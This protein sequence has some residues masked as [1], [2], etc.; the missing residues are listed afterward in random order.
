MGGEIDRAA[1][2]DQD[3]VLQ[4]HPDP[5]L[6]D[7]DAGLDGD[8]PARL[9]G[10]VERREVVD[11]KPER[12]PEAVHEIL[13]AGRFLR[14]VLGDLLRRDQAEAEKLVVHLE[15]GS[16]APVA[17]RRA[18]GG[19][20]DRG[21]EDAVDRVVHRALPRGEAA[22]DGIGAGQV[23]VVVGVAGADVDKEQLAVVADPVVGVVVEDAGALPRGDDRL[24]GHLRPV[25]RE[26]VDQLRLEF[27][28]HHPRLEAGE[29][30][31]QADVG[32]VD[33]PAEELHF[34]RILHG[35]QVSHDRRQPLVAVERIAGHELAGVADVAR[36]GLGAVALVL[37][38]IEIDPLTLAH[39]DM[40][41]A[42]QLRQPADARD[43]RDLLGPFLRQ[44]L[45]LPDGEMFVRLAEEEHLP[46]RRV[47]RL[48]REDEHALL[49]LDPGEV[50]EVGSRIDRKRAVAGLRENVGGVDD[51]DRA[52]GE[53]THEL[54]AVGDEQGVVDR[55]VP[56]GFSSGVSRPRRTRRGGRKSYP[57]GR[58]SV[59]G[60]G[61]WMTHR[62][63]PGTYGVKRALR[64]RR[65]PV[66][67][68]SPLP[69]MASA[70]SA[71]L[72]LSPSGLR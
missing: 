15:L 6:R 2:G 20:G 36:I 5:F 12:M 52:R 39:Q 61:R 26:L 29:H 47:G 22:A 67:G 43:P 50:E 30:P 48:R 27:V 68:R 38:R 25:L 16:P 14:A 64:G 62:P 54:T 21:V 44:L 65:C 23:G 24:V 4:T 7:V 18:D 71:P 1:G 37:V 8:H 9:E 60:L 66:A 45:P 33:R 70:L 34:G 19:P 10:P 17:R 41:H 56:H 13:P 63:A 3:V 31:P 46:L 28:F 51:R 72:A 69:S 35:A 59:A 40:E 53:L 11:A 58:A 55:G 42:G 49:L 32:D 57:P